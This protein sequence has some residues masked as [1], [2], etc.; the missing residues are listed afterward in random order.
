[1]Q[2]FGRELITRYFDPQYGPEY[3][4]KLSEHPSEAQQLFATNYLDR[5]AAGRPQQ[6]AE[7][8]PYFTAI[9]SRVNKGRL[10]KIR[11]LAFL[12][13]EALASAEAAAIVAPLLAR[14]VVTI[15]I[16]SKA[17]LIETMVRV[18][19]QYPDI[20]LPV[21]VQAPQPKEAPHGV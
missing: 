18:R 20:A 2:Q 12:E 13:K 5:F 4:L 7:L 19:E 9:L 10:A 1:V 21:A 15:A 16:E 17:A 11:A 3:L 14:Q 6:L 8:L